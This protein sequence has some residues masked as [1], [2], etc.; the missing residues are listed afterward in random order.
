M[1]MGTYLNPGNSGFSD[2]RQAKYVDKSG[3][4][5]IVNSTLS[6][7]F[8]LTCVSRPRRF[9]KSYAAQM[10]CAYYDMSC[11]S[12]H[13][14]E[15]LKIAG[16]P[17]YEEHLNRYPVIYLDM[18]G[19]KAMC[20]GYATLVPFI[21][22]RITQELRDVYPA[23]M[24]KQDFLA[25]L[26]DTV[27][28]TGVRFIMIID[29]WDAPLREGIGEAGDLLY[30]DFLRS[31]FKNSGVTSKLFAAVYMTGILPIRKIK[32]QSALSDFEEYTML[33]PGPFAEYVGFT[34]A[35][36]ETLCR[37]YHADFAEM[38]RW[39]DGYELRNAGSVYNPNSVIKSL[40]YEAFDSYWLQSTSADSLMDY[41]KWDVDGLR[42]KILEL[43]GGVE[44]RID[45]T[46]YNNG[47]TYHTQDAALTMLVHLGYLAYNQDTRKVRIPNE[48]IRLEF[49]RV[50]REDRHPETIKRVRESDQ[51][52][53]D[54]IHGNEA[55]VAER[56][57]RVHMETTNPLNANNENSL[58]AVI[59]IAYFSY[60]DYYMK[61]E[62]L[63][64]GLGYA[65]I[66]YLP[67]KDIQIPALVVELKWNNSAQGAIRQIRE[68][69]YPAVLEEY[70]GEILLVGI[71]YDRDLKE[72]ECKIETYDK[73]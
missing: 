22:E 69:H 52:I 58:R 56:I 37:E 14:F 70:G 23:L 30:L 68:K 73:G 44:I 35:E 33:R 6:T 10:L 49:A 3:M 65:D 50:I 67:K 71:N 36:A 25:V 55:A 57:R 28:L 46:G 21:K 8:K 16:M 61:L 12:G 54:T 72:Y 1:K 64:S 5:S 4:I 59:Q 62:G 31:L 39:Y 53:M 51:L 41:I 32:T 63:P 9:G 29:E 15:D 47:L 13:L 2:I 24:P 19:I 11:D 43:M 26:I 45:I 42:E 20:D 40:R 7:P 34:E 18:A 27:S 60:R 17:G 66:V 38:K 48:E